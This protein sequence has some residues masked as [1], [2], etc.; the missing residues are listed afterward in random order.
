M[1]YNRQLEKLAK[2]DAARVVRAAKQVLYLA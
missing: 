1:P 2:P